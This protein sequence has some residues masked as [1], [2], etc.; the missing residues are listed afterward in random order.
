MSGNTCWDLFSSK[1]GLFIVQFSPYLDCKHVIIWNTVAGNNQE[2]FSKTQ[3]YKHIQVYTHLNN[4]PINLYL[5]ST[6]LKE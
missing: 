2:S 3:L 6:Y 5:S 1:D 4:M